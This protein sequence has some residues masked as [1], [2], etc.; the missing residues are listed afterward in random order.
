MRTWFT[1]GLTI[2]LAAVVI[3]NLLH[4]YHQPL[5]TMPGRP[6]PPF[7]TGWLLFITLGGVVPIAIQGKEK[8]RERADGLIVGMTTM[9]ALAYIAMTY[10]VGWPTMAL[11][12][13]TGVLLLVH[14][15]LI[16]IVPSVLPRFLHLT[17]TQGS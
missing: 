15:V 12:T 5:V 1:W 17:E 3:T 16:Y 11:A 6:E 8:F 4:I 13:G 7:Q 14:L 2:A 9:G 10:F